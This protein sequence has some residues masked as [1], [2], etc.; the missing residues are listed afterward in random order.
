MRRPPRGPLRAG[1][2]S[3]AARRA[4][5]TGQITKAPPRG[6]CSTCAAGEGIGG[7][8]R[9]ARA[10]AAAGAA[11]R[12]RAGRAL[13]PSGVRRRLVVVLVVLVL[14]VVR[15][16]GAH[17]VARGGRAREEWR[18]R[19][20]DAP[21]AGAPPRRSAAPPAARRRGPLAPSV[22]AAR[23]ARSREAASRA[24]RS[25]RSCSV[26]DD[27]S[28]CSMSTS[29]DPRAVSI[30]GE[31]AA[32]TA[33]AV[34]RRV[35]G[36]PHAPAV[37]R[38]TAPDAV[39]SSRAPAFASA[40]AARH[41]SRADRSWAARRHGRL[42]GLTLA[43]RVGMR[44]APPRAR[45]AAA[46]LAAP[47]AAAAAARGATTRRGGRCRQPL[48]ANTYRRSPT[49]CP[50]SRSARRAAPRA[51]AGRAR[52]AA[53]DGRR[54]PRT[55]RRHPPGGLLAYVEY[56]PRRRRGARA[57]PSSSARVRPRPAVAPLAVVSRN[58]PR[59]ALAPRRVP[60]RTG[61]DHTI[62]ATLGSNRCSERHPP[63][64]PRGP[65]R[66]L[67]V[68]KESL[69]AAVYID[70]AEVAGDRRGREGEARRRPRRAARRCRGAR[71]RL[72]I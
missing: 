55:A 34:G 45:L 16:R 62:T 28:T 60:V 69:A 11:R 12:R 58:N 64:P 61:G 67:A 10:R 1:P 38:P 48:L 49:T 6:R 53:R 30:K 63:P 29:L 57:P 47:R 46:A 56:P 36:H 2:A 3:V 17:P 65:A 70:P 25:R 7:Q 18:G 22:A 13:S 23:L 52:A 9:A 40:R 41:V 31:T 66:A 21:R 44:K 27:G 71:A 8:A 51:R 37:T 19:R 15:G 35:L 33:C 59:A 24:M 14:G 72:S 39:S 26:S 50:S 20:E 32:D 43:R 5:C 4:G 68:V 54:R 42:D